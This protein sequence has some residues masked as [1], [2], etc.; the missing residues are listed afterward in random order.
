MLTLEYT[1]K[2]KIANMKILTL[3]EWIYLNENA[4]IYE[5]YDG[6]AASTNNKLKGHFQRNWRKYA[7]GYVTPNTSNKKN[8]NQ[9]PKKK[10]KVSDYVPS[11][12]G[13]FGLGGA[14]GLEI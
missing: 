6:E 8:I 9:K 3:E 5:D 12:F 1:K 2:E 10:F 7:L 4:D 14:I 11:P 13:P